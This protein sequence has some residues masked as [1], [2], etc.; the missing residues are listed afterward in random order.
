MTVVS[1]LKNVC[2]HSTEVSPLVTTRNPENGDGAQLTYSS[3][4]HKVDIRK[5]LLE[6]SSS[7]VPLDVAIKIRPV[8]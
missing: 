2:M 8:L 6:V 4:F 5:L 7:H 1:V 3:I